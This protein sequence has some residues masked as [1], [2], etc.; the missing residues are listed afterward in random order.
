ML[1]ISLNPCFKALFVVENLVGH[2]NAIRLAFK[3][4]GFKF[5]FPLLMVSFD[6]LNPTTTNTRITTIEV[7]G[8]DLE[9]NMFG[10]G[11]HSLF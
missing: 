5:S 11:S 7:F 2:G 4:D 9:K 8:E 10:V 1:A 6:W 3:Y